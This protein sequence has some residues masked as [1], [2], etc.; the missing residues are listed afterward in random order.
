MK[1]K[2]SKNYKKIKFGFK[3][4][5]HHLT[6]KYSQFSIGFPLDILNVDINLM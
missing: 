2:R 3:K 4:Y 5:I 6:L 1:A